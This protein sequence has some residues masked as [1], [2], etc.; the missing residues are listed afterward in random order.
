MPINGYPRYDEQQYR[1][2]HWLDGSGP[3]PR[4]RPDQ[5]KPWRPGQPK[6]AF[7]LPRDK[8]VTNSPP[9]SWRRLKDIMT[10]KGPGI[11]IGDRR[12]FGP[13]RPTWSN[14][15]IH[16]NLGYRNAHDEIAGFYSGPGNKRYDFYTRKYQIPTPQ[17]W[18]DAK[19]ERRRHPK[20][21]HYH[22]YADGEEWFDLRVGQG[23][24]PGKYSNLFRY[25]MNSP[26][27]DWGRPRKD[28]FYGRYMPS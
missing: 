22:R 5:Q 18:S 28:N 16:D 27:F 23:R 12:K 3:V 8:G 15:L 24:T 14:W 6:A 13:H 17:T 9:H 20:H 4:W 25:K 7:I 2:P 26:Y 10:G 1:D 11:W 21:S 19:W